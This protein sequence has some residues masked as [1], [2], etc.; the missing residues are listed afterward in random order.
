MKLLRLIRSHRVHILA[1]FL[2]VILLYA[3][4]FS[5]L[6][7]PSIVIHW[8]MFFAH[9]PK[10]L[11][12][13]SID[14]HKLQQDTLHSKLSRYQSLAIINKQRLFPVLITI[15]L[16]LLL[17]QQTKLRDLQTA[18]WYLS[19]NQAFVL[20]LVIISGLGTV[21]EFPSMDHYVT[22]HQS[23]PYHR[24]YIG[25]TICLSLLGSYLINVQVQQLGIIWFFIATIAGVLIFL[26]GM[27]L[28][29]E[30]EEK[31]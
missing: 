21:Y 1:D 5:E 15:Y 11:D 14:Y 27:M 24:A 2:C 26:V 25:L 9:M 18:T 8:Y 16:V 10:A 22:H 30:D 23:L 3:L 29:E 28:L 31:E 4:G 13:T 19:I 6:I 17:I 12:M 7:I 20:F